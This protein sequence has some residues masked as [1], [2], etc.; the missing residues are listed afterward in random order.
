MSDNIRREEHASERPL[1]INYVFAGPSMAGGVK[2]GR[3]IAEALTRRGHDVRIIFPTKGR[4]MPAPW[5]PRA[6]LK[7]LSRSFRKWRNATLQ[8]RQRHHLESST[9]Q[10]IPVPR[11]TLSADD[12]PDGDFCIANFWKTREQ[13]ETWPESKGIKS[14]YLRGN[15]FTPTGIDTAHNIYSIGGVYISVGKQLIDTLFANNPHANI[16]YAPNGID[17]SQFDSQPR[18]R[19]SDPTIGFLYSTA[20]IK[21]ADTAIA[22]IR[23][24]YQSFPNLQVTTFGSMPLAQN[25]N[26]ID[27]ILHYT[28][29][30]QSMISSIYKKADCWIV[31]ST[32][33]GL[34][35][36]GLEA[37]ACRCPVVATDC[38]G[39]ADYIAHGESGYL[40]PVGDANAMAEAILEVLRQSDKAWRA[41][42]EASY[43]MSLKFDWD[44]SAAQIER[45]LYK[46][47]D[48]GRVCMTNRPKPVAET[49]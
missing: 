4:A 47:L 1:R 5:K 7:S 23:L 30:P 12:V 34:A 37:M 22:A 2:S 26:Q 36:P 25:H 20:S 45:G 33:E 19:Q 29:P 42:S 43:A 3:L 38:G 44:A 27:N 40:V 39:P 24:L 16:I 10:L 6:F 9:A 41:M 49:P 17:R 8:G 14:F 35:M 18:V 28:L 21:G 31:P 32:S 13:I 15:V 48:T 11:D 46:Y